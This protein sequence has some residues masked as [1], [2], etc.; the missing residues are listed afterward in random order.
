MTLREVAL[1]AADAC[2]VPDRRAN[3]R[4]GSWRGNHARQDFRGAFVDGFGDG[5]AS[6]ECSY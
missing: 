1:A 4:A 5:G 2:H 3:N 6:P